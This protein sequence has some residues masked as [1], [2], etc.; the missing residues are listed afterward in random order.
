MPTP[1]RTSL[2]AI[3]AAGRDILEFGGTVGLTMHA[4]AERV[5]VKAPSLYKRVKDRGAM[6]C[7]VADA[8]VDDLAS[9]LDVVDGLPAL[10]RTFRAF[11][12]ERPE[13][14]RLIFSGAASLDAIARASAP[15]L[16]AAGELAGEDDALA[17]ARLVTAWATGFVTM[18][19]AGAFQLG[20]DVDRAFEF[21]LDRLSR[22]L[23]AP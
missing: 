12:H 5:G 8:T 21:G 10:A 20:G 9:R 18:E 13:G 23:S 6:Q 15:V 1:E 7:L 3:V 17:A 19:L 11:A 22:A 4:V 14:F 16:R 2:D